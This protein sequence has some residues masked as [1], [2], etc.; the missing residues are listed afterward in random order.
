MC[1]SSTSGLT[2][3]ALI[4]HQF[5]ST[6]FLDPRILPLGNLCFGGCDLRTWALGCG[7][8]DFGSGLCGLSGV[9]GLLW[10]LCRLVFARK[11]QVYFYYI[12]SYPV[13]LLVLY[14][15]YS[16]KHCLHLSFWWADL[17]AGSG[18]HFRERGTGMKY[19]MWIP[20]RNTFPDPRGRFE[21]QAIHKV[22]HR[23]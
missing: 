19:P 21:P 10:M 3:H 4:P 18:V 12:Y 20:S 6:G 5:R 7:F 16:M 13:M 8:W 17:N 14:Y 15:C 23:L 9:T 1:A 2:C 11:T 22:V